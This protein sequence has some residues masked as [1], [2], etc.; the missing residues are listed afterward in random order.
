[1]GIGGDPQRR[2]SAWF[3]LPTWCARAPSPTTSGHIERH[4]PTDPVPGSSPISAWIESRADAAGPDAA[5]DRGGWDAAWDRADQVMAR[6]AL[7]R[8]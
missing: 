8:R 2:E 1:M 6:L 5:G 3:A 4:A 7:T